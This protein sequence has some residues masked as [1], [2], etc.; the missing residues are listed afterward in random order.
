MAT[1][2]AYRRLV[3]ESA[4]IAANPPPFVIARPLESN[5]LEWHYIV[6]GPPGTPYEG[7]EYHGKLIFPDTYPFK[8]PAIKM[9]TPNGKKVS[10]RFQTLLDDERLSPF[11]LEET[12]T[13]GSIKTSVT[14]RRL[15]ARK[16]HTFNLGNP[17]FVAVFPDYCTPDPRPLPNPPPPPQTPS[18]ASAGPA[19]SPHQ[20]Q[21][22]AQSVSASAPAADLRKRPTPT[23][24]A[25]GSATAA[26]TGVQPA[27]APDDHAALAP[28]AAAAAAAAVLAWRATRSNFAVLLLL[29]VL[30]YLVALKIVSRLE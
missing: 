20:Q 24:R 22:T 1:K 3:K 29:A 12:P 4:A 21:P 2:A 18:D 30:G 11:M 28:P 8:P 6:R 23:Q 10:N 17:K 16:S 26:V 27:A 7:G 19:S 13:T 15:L 14:E 5:I 9:L 25:A